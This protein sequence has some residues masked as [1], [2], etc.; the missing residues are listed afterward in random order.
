MQVIP[1]VLEKDWDSIEKKLNQIK[2]FTNT[3]HVDII[4]GKFVNNLTFLD[5]EPFSKYSQDLFLELH[6]MVQDPINLLNNWGKAGFKRFLGHIEHMSSQNE[7]IKEAKRFGEVGLALDGP[8][9]ISSIKV[10]FEELDSLLIYT[11]DRVGFSGPPLME[12]RL[13]KIRHLR[14]LT[15]IP[16]GADGGINDKTIAKAHESGATRFVSTSCIWT[17]PNPAESYHNLVKLIR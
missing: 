3:V 1:G 4:D 5:P 11:S 6:M 16:I 14:K 7:F 10:P 13:D 8:T 17:A 2:T 12:D 15:N 9:H